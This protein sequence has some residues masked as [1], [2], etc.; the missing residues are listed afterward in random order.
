MF[1]IV[2][3]TTSICQELLFS[4]NW[5]ICYMYNNKEKTMWDG[6]LFKD[7]CCPQGGLQHKTNHIIN[8]TFTPQ[9]E[10]YSEWRL[11]QHLWVV[12]HALQETD[13]FLCISFCPIS[14][15]NQKLNMPQGCISLLMSSL[16]WFNMAAFCFLCTSFLRKKI[17]TMIVF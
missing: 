2:Q 14:A 8:S 1:Y 16:Q 15:A 4:L 7:T 11:K 9:R 10:I 17:V 3:A 13:A 5:T 6:Y 12:L